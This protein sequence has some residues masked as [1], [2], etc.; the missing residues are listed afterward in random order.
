MKI[1]LT[2]REA[3]ILELII[4]EFTSMEIAQELFITPETVK[5]HR[6]N[7]LMKLNARNVAGM[8]RRAFE[9]NIVSL[10]Q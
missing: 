3:E 5:S 7:L 9:Y 2:S 6:K 4:L 1:E 8:V 10:Y